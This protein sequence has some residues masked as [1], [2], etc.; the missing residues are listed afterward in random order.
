MG[1]IVKF[2]L[3]LSII[4]LTGCQR[5]GGSS[6]QMISTSTFL[7]S[8]SSI[9]SI[10][11]TTK[12]VEF[13]TAG[14]SFGTTFTAGTQFSSIEHI[15]NNKRLTSY[16]NEMSADS[17]IITSIDCDSC[18]SQYAYKQDSNTAHLTLGTQKSIG[19]FT[20]NF[21]Y[22][23]KEV[24]VNTQVYYSYYDDY[25]KP[26]SYIYNVDVGAKL[27]IET[28]EFDLDSEAGKQSN[29][30]DKVFTLPEPKMSLTLGN[31]EDNSHR[32]FINSILITYYN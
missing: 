9:T 11:S 30:V 21:K 20:I 28:Q 22:F 1:K 7:P 8:N 4:S 32:V 3:F 24:K 5:V 17:E 2:I 29:A 26:G 6:N 25:E 31:M 13:V 23:I 12:Q 10:P 14:G 19:K 16:L 15:D 27:C 18:T